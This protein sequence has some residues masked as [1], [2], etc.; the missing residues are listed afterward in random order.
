MNRK[1][2]FGLGYLFSVIGGAI[3]LAT[4][5]E[6]KEQKFVGIQAIGLWAISVA[7]NILSAF[8]GYLPVIGK[9]SWIING[10]VSVGYFVLYLVLVIGAF[11]GKHKRIPVVTDYVEQW[12]DFKVP[13]DCLIRESAQTGTSA[14]SADADNS[15]Q[16]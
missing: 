6:D 9:L 1:T 10:V 8:I 16:E 12:S 13:D 5:N 3:L 15:N 4:A 7:I 2:K 11:T 14:K